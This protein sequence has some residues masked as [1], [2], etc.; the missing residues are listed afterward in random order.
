VQSPSVAQAF[1]EGSMTEPQSAYP[2]SRDPSKLGSLE[3]ASGAAASGEGM[4]ASGSAPSGGDP[5]VGLDVGVGASPEM[6]ASPARPPASPSPALPL[7]EPQ[8]T[9]RSKAGTTRERDEVEAMTS[10]LCGNTLT[11]RGLE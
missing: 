10:I 2:E 3:N 4:T 11:G 8:A 5:V 9:A 1:K 6:D 7:E